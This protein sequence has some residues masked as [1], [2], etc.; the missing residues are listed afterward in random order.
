MTAGCNL[1]W[2]SPVL[3]K[4]EQP[5]SPIH[6]TPEQGSWIGSLMP[7]G[8]IVGP[9]LGGYLANKIGKCN[10]VSLITN[11]NRALIEI[12]GLYAL[13]SNRGQGNSKLTYLQN[14]VYFYKS[15]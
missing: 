2:T 11:N 9:F 1:G 7:L 12:T 14:S 13:S 3:P 6:I 5:D 10:I 15:T 8:A 4:L